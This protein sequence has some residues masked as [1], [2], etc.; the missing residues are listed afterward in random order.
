MIRRVSPAKLLMVGVLLVMLASTASIYAAGIAG[1]AKKLGST[2]DVTVAAPSATANVTTWTLSST[3][4]V[5]SVVVTWTPT[6]SANYSVQV[7]LKNSGG[8]VI[9]SGSLAVTNS[10][11]SQRN[12]TVNITQV[13]VDPALVVTA[14]VN[15]SQTG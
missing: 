14:V 13:D 4:N 5:G 15:I 12:D 2:G 7:V 8:A 11:T 6:S 9:G 1:T 10:G 3:G